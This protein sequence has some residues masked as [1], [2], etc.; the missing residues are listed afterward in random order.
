MRMS[1]KNRDNLCVKI[2]QNV[3]VMQHRQM[4]MGPPFILKNSLLKEV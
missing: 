1:S 3:L 4:M 2:I